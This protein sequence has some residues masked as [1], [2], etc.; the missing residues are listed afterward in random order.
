MLVLTRK[1]N[2]AILIGQNVRILAQSIR[3]NQ[4]RLGIE[5]P[6]SVTIQRKE[7]REA[8]ASSEARRP[9]TAVTKSPTPTSPIH[10]HTGRPSDRRSATP[11]S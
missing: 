8:A 6:P 10:D 4:I 5:A 7:L 11:P 3:G 2:Q 1:I 9:A